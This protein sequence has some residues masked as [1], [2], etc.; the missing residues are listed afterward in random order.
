VDFLQYYDLESY[1]FG[2]VRSRFA[3]QGCLSAF[4]FF[5]IVIWKANRAKS[6]IAKRLLSRGY[7]DLDTAARALTTDLARC[8]SARDRL[9]CL[10]RRWGFLLP[11]AS[12][13]LTVLHPDEFTVYD[14]RVC[15]QLG[16]FHNLASVTDFDRLWL[17]YT[18][19]RRGVEQSAPG[20]LSLRDK[21]RYLWGKSFHEQ[22]SEDIEQGFERVAAG[23]T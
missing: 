12:A 14:V 22:L 23:D 18:D 7:Q 16:R 9:E 17:G 5:C 10:I 2:A 21:D 3:E 8:R 4:D 6:R 13:I 11:M 15:D 1:L 20:H 19:F